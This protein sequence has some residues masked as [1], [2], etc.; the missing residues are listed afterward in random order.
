MSSPQPHQAGY[1]SYMTGYVFIKIMNT[2]HLDG[3]YKSSTNIIHQIL[4]SDDNKFNQLYFNK[5]NIENGNDFEIKN[6]FFKL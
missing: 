1:D 4:N 5:I 6:K 3:V 2:I